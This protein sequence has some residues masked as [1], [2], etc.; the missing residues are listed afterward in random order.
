LLDI[1]SEGRKAGIC[2]LAA[3][4]IDTAEGM[5]ISGEKDMLK[6]FDMILYLGAMATKYVPTA[7][8]MARPAVVY[9]PEHDVWAQLII[10]LPTT[11][12]TGE[13]AFDAEEAPTAPAQAAPAPPTPAAAPPSRQGQRVFDAPASFAAAPDD[14]L[15]ELLARVGTR[16]AMAPAP[17]SFAEISALSP[18]RAVRLA[19][20][21]GRQGAAAAPT[22]A[23]AP[24]AAPLARVPVVRG[25]IGRTN[26][27][28][29]AVHPAGTS[30][31][32]AS[33]DPIAAL[34]LGAAPAPV[35]PSMVTAS[36]S[37][38]GPPLSSLR[39]APIPTESLT[40]TEQRLT[41]DQPGGAQF[42]FN[43]QQLSVPPARP[44]ARSR[45]PKQNGKTHRVSPEDQAMLP[46]ARELARTVGKTAAIRHVYDRPHGARYSAIARA[47]DDP[48]A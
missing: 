15:T 4:H 43:M 1:L 24:V 47:F 28:R 20:I 7:A 33:V 37:N 39:A 44:A 18:D 9:D 25:T 42:V 48:T 32:V 22:A 17:L 46:Q 34:A 40:G 16:T 26:R 35:A 14:L 29:S 38:V 11:T 10:A 45:Q 13:P 36:T 21:L 3:S 27:R 2:A 30:E 6:C 19:T 8:R 23:P 12:D 31:P 41:L 5:G